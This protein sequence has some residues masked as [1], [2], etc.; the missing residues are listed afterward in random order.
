MKPL[1]YVFAQSEFV[2]LFSNTFSKTNNAI[3]F[4]KSH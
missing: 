4:A 1:N 2:V 3:C